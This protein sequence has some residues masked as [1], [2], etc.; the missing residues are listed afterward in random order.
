V[1]DCFA[2]PPCAAAPCG[3]FAS[4]GRVELP[5]IFFLTPD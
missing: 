2:A 4:A 1:L 5:Q 3:D